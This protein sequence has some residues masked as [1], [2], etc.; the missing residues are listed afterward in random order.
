MAKIVG[1]V[2]TGSGRVGNMVLSKGPNGLTISRSYQP[3]VANP[4]TDGQ[5][6]HRAK[7][8]LAGRVSKLV[9]SEA[10]TGLSMGS[11]KL[12]RSEFNSN[13]IK[14]CVVS[15]VSG[16]WQASVA[17]ERVIFSHGTETPSATMGTIA[18]TANSVTLPLSNVTVDGQHGERVVVMVLN[19][20]IDGYYKR[21]QFMDVIYTGSQS[22]IVMNLAIPLE[23][24]E[25]VLV[26]RCPFALTSRKRK[27]VTSPV[28]FD[29]NI[30]AQLQLTTSPSA[31]FGQSIYH[32]SAVF[33]A[34]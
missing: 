25:M 7:I 2:G 17:P 15:K 22:S 6:E 20:D 19:G 3:V 26:Y 14:A 31:A 24:D 13:L 1:L 11:N 23:D 12:N 29:K 27:A 30:L 18:V 4:R 9:P 32:G 21:C 16:A 34:A 33:T 10:I 28:Y 8:N 5:M